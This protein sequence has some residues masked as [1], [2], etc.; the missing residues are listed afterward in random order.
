[1]QF[2]YFRRALKKLHMTVLWTG[3]DWGLFK[4]NKK[5]KWK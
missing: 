2:I 4:K 3:V 1:M 5:G